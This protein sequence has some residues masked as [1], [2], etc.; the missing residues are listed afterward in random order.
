MVAALAVLIPAGYACGLLARR[1]PA[2]VERLPGALLPLSAEAVVPGLERD[3]LWPDLAIRTRT[4]RIAGGQR[5]IVELEPR[6]DPRLP[7]LLVYWAGDLPGGPGELPP[8][9]ILLGTLPGSRSTRLELPPEA[10]DGDG[11]LLLYSLAHRRIVAAS[12]PLGPEAW[13]WP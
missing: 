13:P 3:D 10:A 7:D 5:R 2:E 12:A 6:D 1:P 11:R 9:S 4:G 8:S